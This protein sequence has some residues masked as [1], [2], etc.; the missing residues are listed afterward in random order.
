M[1]ETPSRP[2]RAG[3]IGVG[4]MGE[5]H[6]RVYSELQDV[7]LACVADHDEEVARRVADAYAT[8]AV[9]FETVLE[10]CDVVTVAVPTRAHYDVVSDCLNADVHVLVEKP[11]AETTEQG[12]ALAELAEER[13][14]VLQVGHI[15]RFN[16]A[17]QTVTDLVED[18]DVISVEAERLGPPLDR[19]ALGNVV[20]DLMVHDLDI[21]ASL[22]EDRPDSVTATGTESGQYATATLEFDDVVASLT[23]S[24]VT[25]KKVRTLTVTARE[26][27]VEVDYLEQSVLI[28]R[29]SYPEY[30]TD[31]GKRRYRHESVVERPRVDNGE[32]LRHELESFVEAARNGSEPVVTAEDGIR[33]LEMVQTIDSLVTEETEKREVEA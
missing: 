7:E 21:V 19:T 20:F 26:C 33:A 8:D 16:P 12:R 27:L 17:V 32:P 31:D 30:L 1:N 23:A 10:R 13:G 2:I 6:A 15:E 14:L 5:N 18:L 3:V 28:H 25:Q 9:A 22:L 4:S 24:R 11:I 29:D